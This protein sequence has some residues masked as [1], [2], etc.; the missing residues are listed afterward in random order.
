MVDER[1][2][3]PRVDRQGGAWRARFCNGFTQQLVGFVGQPLVE[4]AVA[5]RPLLALADGVA[6]ESDAS[7]LGGFGRLDG[8][9]GGVVVQPVQD[10]LALQG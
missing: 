5:N 8:N 1:E 6:L 3:R 4:F 7:I 9:A 10:V 2:P